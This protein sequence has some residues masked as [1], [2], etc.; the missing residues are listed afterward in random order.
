MCFLNKC[1]YNYMFVYFLTMYGESESREHVDNPEFRRMGVMQY[2]HIIDT[3][4][5]TKSTSTS[6]TIRTE[7]DVAA[8]HVQ[9]I[10]DLMTSGQNVTAVPEA[11]KVPDL[12]AKPLKID[13]AAEKPYHGLLDL[14]HSLAQGQQLAQEVTGTIRPA[15]HSLMLQDAPRSAVAPLAPAAAQADLRVH[16]PPPVD[17]IAPVVAAAPNP[18]AAFR[19]AANVGQD[20]AVVQCASLAQSAAQTEVERVRQ[21]AELLRARAEELKSAF[22]N[23]KKQLKSTKAALDLLQKEQ[24]EVKV[25]EERL[26]T[27]GWGGGSREIPS[28]RQHG[29]AAQAQR[30]ARV[31]GCCESRI[32]R[33]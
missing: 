27:K 30:P 8:E 1:H 3:H 11:M 12:P 14:A 17:Q 18:I 2:A 13:L 31:V 24:G 29:A 16:A 9:G 19:S 28:G 5:R 33:G 4:D 22:D 20:A 7:A 6:S 25:C 10:R 21:D 26:R 15:T 23:M 32:R